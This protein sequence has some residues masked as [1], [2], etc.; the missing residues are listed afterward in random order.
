MPNQLDWMY[1]N[2]HHSLFREPFGSVPAGTQVTLRLLIFGSGVESVAIL[3]HKDGGHRQEIPMQLQQRDTEQLLTYLPEQCE[4]KEPPEVFLFTAAI[5]P[6]DPLLY[7]YSF[8]V[9]KEGQIYYYGNVS[10]KGGAGSITDAPTTDYQITVHHPGSKTP[11]WFKDSIMYQIFVD[12][13][14]NGYE[15]GKIKNPKKNSVIHAHWDD[16][17]FYIR[18]PQTNDVICWDFFGGNLRGVLKKLDYLEELGVTVI[19]LNPIFESPSNHKYDTADYH[20]VDPMFGDNRLFAKL[21]KKAASKGMSIILDGVFS[22]TGSDSR[23][24]NKYGTYPELGAYQSKE[25]PYYSWY[26]FREYPDD[27]ECWWNIPVLPNVNELDP[28]FITFN[29]TGE[30]SVLK[31][32]LGEGA[33]GW[34]LDVADELPDEFIKQFRQ[35]LKQTD[36]ESVLIGE[37]WEDASNKISYNKRRE[38]LLGEELDSVMNYPLRTSLLAFITGQCT[39]KQL[40]AELMSLYENYPAHHFYSLMNLLSSHDVM[41]IATALKDAAPGELAAEDKEKHVFKQLQLLVLWQ[42][43]FPGVPCIYYGDEAGLEGGTDPLNRRTYPWGREKTELLDWHRKMTSLRKTYDV[44]RTGEWEPFIADSDVFG[45]IRRISGGADR[46]GQTKQDN[47]AIVVANRHL[48][49]PKK[50]TIQTGVAEL[51]EFIE[52][53][54]TGEERDGGKIH[55]A[56]NGLITIELP[57]L[58]GLVLI[59]K[60]KARV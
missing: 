33:A 20:T 6:A 59:D 28:G 52:V 7:W 54:G 38:Y 37:V 48:T 14:N 46:F 43:T 18:D 10:G 36:P 58:S 60:D 8:K 4:I 32:W 39:D 44:F 19:Y 57:P 26:K 49:E 51:S 23:Y 35:T 50:V 3:L 2:S 17:P 16:D 21:C 11:S 15:D 1:H 25:S 24:F 53:A 5:T 30:N 22:H 31:K 45:Y 9:Q 42:M 34:R 40:Y 47:T 13:F 56:V 27:Y 29:I 12:R 55:Q 41:R